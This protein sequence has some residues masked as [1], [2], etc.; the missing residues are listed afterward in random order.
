MMLHTITLQLPEN[1]YLRLRQA[2]HA[3]KQ[4]LNDI[5]LRAVEMGSPPDVEDVP[6]EYRADL[7]GLDHLDDN[8]LWN[9][10]RN[11]RQEADFSG[12]DELL[13]K[14][15]DGTV[16]G[17][18]RRRLAELRAESD[19]F[20]LRKAHAAALLRWRGHKMLPVQ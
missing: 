4:S 16:S 9:I 2:A 19:R 1:I 13:D 20:M 7:I 11:V 14:N 3:T 18:E 17:E 15:R 10:V 12:Y 5:I 8:A 6:A